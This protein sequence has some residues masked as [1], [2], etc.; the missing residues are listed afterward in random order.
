[1]PKELLKK[2]VNADS[3]RNQGEL[4]AARVLK[5]FFADHNIEAQIDIWDE[6]RAN[7]TVHLKGSGSVA[8]LIF[9][10]H[11]DV[12]PPGEKPWQTPPFEATEKDSK[13]FGRGTCDMKAGTA[14]IAVAAAQIANSDIKL[15]G[16]LVITATA[17][18]ETDSCG[19]IK[20]YEDYK[21][22]MS[23]PA[24]VILPEPTNFEI[25]TG[26]RGIC[27][28]RITSLGKTAHGSMP[29]LGI[30][31]IS[32][33]TKLLEKLENFDFAAEDHP[34]FG[35][36]SM[37]I[38][39]IHGGNATNVIPDRCSIDLDIRITPNQSPQDIINKISNII[40]TIKADY[41]DFDAQIE[42]LRIIDAMAT[43]TDCDFVKNICEITSIKET[44]VV[45]YTTDGPVLTKFNAPVIVFGPGQSALAHQPDEYIETKDL[46]TAADAYKKIIINF[47]T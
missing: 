37:S 16:D 15:K 31:A 34:L 17:G 29:H 32:S 27:W 3:T 24:G 18:E 26:H 28:L 47:L 19:I 39:Q 21:D 20:F 12:V 8:P 13:I 33:M 30:N 14:A 4:Q 5:Q 23:T 38:N 43:E 10:C 7:I 44:K 11:L 1:M 46:T 40:K 41:P 36:P 25:V 9:A 42:P 6:N 2:L 35:K 22:K 45:G